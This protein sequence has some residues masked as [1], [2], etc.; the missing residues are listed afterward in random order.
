MI[1]QQ[2]ARH[3]MFSSPGV[4]Q[5]RF[6]VL[7]FTTVFTLKVWEDILYM[8]AALENVSGP[9][10][11]QISRRGN[12]RHGWFCRRSVVLV[13]AGFRAWRF[14]RARNAMRVGAPERREFHRMLTS[15]KTDLITSPQ[16][17]T[18]ATLCL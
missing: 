5:K 6:P 4:I 1:R 18:S 7:F 3:R 16:K 17:A 10:V 8:P 2:T 15:T 13:C 9:Y 14:V 11:V 12:G